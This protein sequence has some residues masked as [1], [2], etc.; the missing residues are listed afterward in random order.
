MSTTLPETSSLECTSTK[1]YREKNP[2]LSEVCLMVR[3]Y[4]QDEA[5]DPQERYAVYRFYGA[6]D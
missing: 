6:L 2:Y 4:M 1:Q 3:P 5:N